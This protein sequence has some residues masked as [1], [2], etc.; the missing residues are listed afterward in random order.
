MRIDENNLSRD[1]N[2]RIKCMGWLFSAK[3]IDDSLVLRICM[4]AYDKNFIIQSGNIGV[5]LAGRLYKT[6]SIKRI[7]FNPL[8]VR[9]LKV[10]IKYVDL[11]NAAIHSRLSLVFSDNKQLGFVKPVAFSLFKGIRGRGK[12]RALK[13]IEESNTTV[14]VRQS[15]RNRVYITQRRKNTSDNKILNKK[16]TLAYYFSFLIR[17]KKTMLLYEKESM[18][19]EESASVLYE[20]LID[21]GYDNVF[22]VLDAGSNHWN[23]IKRKYRK[24]VLVKHSFKHYILFFVSKVFAGTEMPAHAIDLRV[25][26]KHAVRK[27]QSKKLKYVFLQHGVMYMISLS[28]D[29]RKPARKGEGGVPLNTKTV[30]SSQLEASHFIEHGGYSENDLFITGLPKFDRSF[31]NKNAKKITIMPTWRPWE[32]NQIRIKPSTTRYYKMMK[33]MIAGV[34]EEYKNNIQLMPHPL[35]IREIENTDLAKYM[36]PFTSYDEVLRDTD[37]LI[38]DYSS[39]AYDAFYRGSKVIFWWKE[40]DY[41]MAEY[42]GTLMINEDNIFGPIVYKSAEMKKLIQSMY[43]SVNSND[44]K[45]RFRKI[46]EFND[47]NNTNRVVDYLFKYNLI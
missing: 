19:Y 9:I 18:K 44:Y 25:A 5:Y 47:N 3:S 14:Y 24:N 33:A 31:K 32:Y 1:Y 4:V 23:Y 41:C 15:V 46:V 34:P 6:N 7:K 20:N 36:K 37:I 45:K 17:Y 2:N 16:I 11:E 39:V 21:R 13:V 28:S 40:K 22:F 27:I 42:G 29:A 43:L 38:T 35:F 12:V 10:K 30:V 26:N 8:Q